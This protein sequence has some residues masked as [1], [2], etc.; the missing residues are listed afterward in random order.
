MIKKLVSP[1]DIRELEA[2]YPIEDARA[3]DWRFRYKERSPGCYVAEGRDRWGRSCSLEG[4]DPDPLLEE[5]VAY[6]LSF[7]KAD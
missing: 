4:G 7:Q 2:A 6:A 5:C 3:P 1:V